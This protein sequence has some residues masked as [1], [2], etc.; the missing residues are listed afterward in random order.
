MSRCHGSCPADP[1]AEIVVMLQNLIK[2]VGPSLAKA[3]VDK[4]GK[5]IMDVLNSTEAEVMLQQVGAGGWRPEREGTP[6]WRRQ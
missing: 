2:G 6:T 3:M 1:L 4:H 5:K